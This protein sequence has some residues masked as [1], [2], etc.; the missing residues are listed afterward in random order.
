MADQINLVTGTYTIR[1]LAADDAF[2]SPEAAPL[3]DSTG[4]PKILK[5]ACIPRGVEAAAVSTQLYHC[6]ISKSDV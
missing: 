6:F 4:P 1:S 5:V 3:G 2:L